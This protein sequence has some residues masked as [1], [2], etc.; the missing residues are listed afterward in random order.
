MQHIPRQNTSRATTTVVLT[1]RATPVVLSGLHVGTVYAV[2]F[3]FVSYQNGFC[4]CPGDIVPPIFYV[5]IV[6]MILTP[7]CYV[8]GFLVVLHVYNFVR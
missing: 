7:C 3:A 4:Q 1:A 5:L 2:P 6:D 8:S